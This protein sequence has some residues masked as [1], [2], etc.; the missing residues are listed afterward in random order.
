[1]SHHHREPSGSGYSFAAIFP[2]SGKIL[3]WDGAR[4]QLLYD[5][6]LGYLPTVFFGSNRAAILDPRVIIF[7][8][9]NSRIEYSPRGQV[10]HA[11]WVQEWLKIHPDWALPG[12]EWDCRRRLKSMEWQQ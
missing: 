8:E 12:C 1:M 6:E 7:N 4:F 2:E 9:D 10:G 11:H 5:P 3:R